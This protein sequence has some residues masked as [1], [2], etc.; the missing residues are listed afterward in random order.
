MQLDTASRSFA[1]KGAPAPSEVK[2][3]HLLKAT[4]RYRVDEK[5]RNSWQKRAQEDFLDVLQRCHDG[6]SKLLR[7]YCK[8]VVLKL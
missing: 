3:E 8:A 2:I 1:E 5:C 7:D 6:G 4:V